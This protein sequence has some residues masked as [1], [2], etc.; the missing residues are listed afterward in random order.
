MQVDALADAVTHTDS[1]G[2]ATAGGTLVVHIDVDSLTDGRHDAT[3]CRTDSGV[4]VPIDVA[5]RLACEA[6]IIPVVLD[7]R[8]VVLDEGRAKRLATVEQRIALQA[9]QTTCSHPDCS[10]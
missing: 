2:S 7:G 3:V 6:D 10:V 9:M 8:G 1:D 5:R 4:D